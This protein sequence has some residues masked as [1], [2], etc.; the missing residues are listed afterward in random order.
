MYHFQK[1]SSYAFLRDFL[2]IS[3]PWAFARCPLLDPRHGSGEKLTEAKDIL[4]KM[5]V[6]FWGRFFREGGHFNTEPKSK[7]D[8]LPS[9][10]LT[11]RTCQ[12]AGPQKERI[13]N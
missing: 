11:V 9:L 1:N 10:K 7:V 2:D 13:G 5:Q 12:E 8:F 4:S 3:Y 6:R